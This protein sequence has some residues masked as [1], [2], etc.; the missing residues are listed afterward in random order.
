MRTSSRLIAALLTAACWTV[1]AHAQSDAASTTVPASAQAAVQASPPALASDSL[2]PAQRKAAD[3]KLKRR[4]S[5]ALAR[6]KNLNV[7]R[8]LVRARDGVVT[9]S[10]SVMDTNQ[11]NLA[12]EVA[13]R[14][15]GVASVSNLL[16]ID[17]QQP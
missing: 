6:T 7:T 2:P 17:G 14:V 3:R 11:A 15:D 8:I 13:R 5:T 10:G 1:A 9:L 16:R 12:A 4:V